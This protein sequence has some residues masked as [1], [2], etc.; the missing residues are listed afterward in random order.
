MIT[1]VIDE[2]TD[3]LK[4]RSTGENVATTYKKSSKIT[5]TKVFQMYTEGW[6][7]DFD[8]ANLSNDGYTVYRLRA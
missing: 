5:K 8:W 1:I 4:R 6:T 2:L 7:H 3:C